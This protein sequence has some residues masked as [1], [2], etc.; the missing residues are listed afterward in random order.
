MGVGAER[1]PHGSTGSL[2]YY[3]RGEGEGEGRVVMR[4]CY[5]CVG[6]GKSFNVCV[7]LGKSCNVCVR[8]GK[9]CHECV[10]MCVLD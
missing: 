3:P 1:G 7:R 9:N 2:C 10:V 5:V 8:L 4:V 6:L